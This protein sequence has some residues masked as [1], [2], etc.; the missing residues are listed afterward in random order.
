M[1]RQAEVFLSQQG[2]K[3]NLG[4]KMKNLSIAESQMLEI[5]KAI[6]VNAKIILM[7]EPTSSLTE[8]EVK[9]LFG[10]IRE[11]K[12]AGITVIYISHKMEEI[13]QVGD[14]ITV[15]RDGEHIGTM[16]AQQT[17]IPE[18][19]E[20]MVGRKMVEVYPEQTARI[21]DV[22][23]RVENFSRKGVFDNIS[24]ELRS[25]EILGVSGLIGAGRTEILRSVI[26]MDPKDNG[27][28]H[29]FGKKVNIR[30]VNDAIS[31]GVV[32]VPEDR[33]RQGL[34]LIGTV[35]DNISLVALQHIFGGQVLKHRGIRELVSRM[36]EE[37]RIRTPSHATR[38]EKLSGGNQ[39]KTVLG[40]WL[41][42]NPRILIMDE[43]T[44]G[45]DVGTK[46][47]IY[48]LMRKI[49][50]QGYAIIL[51]DSDLEELIGM[52]DRVIVIR[53]GS[54]AGELSKKEISANAIM[55]LAAL[56]GESSEQHHA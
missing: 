28:V 15:L 48:K 56:G 13:F 29:I 22:V 27:S 7:D 5:V 42:V 8:N 45:I 24:F 35:E 46:Y 31:N 44:R 33:R 3:F 55:R 12:E 32:M 26:G 6:S 14:Y 25:G 36:V 38:L 52:S 10:K 19:I 53:Q 41:S 21:G 49:C 51:I 34:N 23:F 47:E 2:L 37:L 30:S 18:V 1:K 40:K 16:P 39:Q 20:M 11:L 50:D 9:F 4:S 43:P 54:I 17:S